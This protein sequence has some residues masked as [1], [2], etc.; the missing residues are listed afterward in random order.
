MK[1]VAFMRVATDAVEWGLPAEVG[2][3]AGAVVV[4]AVGMMLSL[5]RSGGLV[6]VLL[7]VLLSLV[8]RVGGR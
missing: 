2:G 1:D 3:G 4:A 6:F 5:R 7:F 8:W